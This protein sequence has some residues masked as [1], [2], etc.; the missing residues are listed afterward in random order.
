M[1]WTRG[2]IIGRGSS[3]TVSV[4]TTSTGDLFAVK[5]TELSSSSF[6]QKEQSIISQLSSPCVIRC[7]GSQITCEEE[8][9]PIYN[10]FLEYVPGGALSDEV[11][12]QGGSLDESMIQFYAHQMIRGLDY[13]HLSGV[14]HGD[15]KGQNILIG[16]DG[17]KIADF[18]CAKLIQEDNDAIAGKSRFSGTPAYMAPEVA[19]GE[20][21]GFPADIWALGCTVIE[22]ATGCT[23]WSEI[24]DPI[25]AMYKIGCSGEVPEFPR[26]LSN[27]TKDFLSKCLIRDAKLRWTAKELLE[28]SLFHGFVN[29]CWE[30]KRESP[31][32]VLDQ[33]F[34]D[35][36]ETPEYSF[37]N[38]PVLASSSYSPADRISC[39]IRDASNLPNWAE[40]E[41]WITV[42]R[43]DF[44]EN[45]ELQENSCS[46]IQDYDEELIFNAESFV[47][48]TVSEEEFLISIAITDYDISIIDIL[49]YESIKDVYV[50]RILDFETLS[51]KLSSRFLVQAILFFPF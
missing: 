17:L 3:A 32:S 39:L 48:M 47:F 43:I 51:V 5:S 1:E 24:H 4:A 26:W 23:P 41:D 6:L 27:K 18:G 2:P 42:R 8:N 20:E 9:K 22:M 30:F 33:G 37:R 38:Q 11:R 36:F 15:I 34:W 25:S 16:K 28:H 31:T 50:S 46:F 44:E 19:R 40:E 35:S 10:L 21:Q 12:K 7:L 29:N 14:V 45:L 49:N 13:L